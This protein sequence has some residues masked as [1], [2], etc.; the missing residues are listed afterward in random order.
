MNI[1][2]KY[3]DTVENS[4]GIFKHGFHHFSK[5]KALKIVH[6]FNIIVRKYQYLDQILYSLHRFQ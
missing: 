1:L 4:N 3:F 6:H 2:N 5:A